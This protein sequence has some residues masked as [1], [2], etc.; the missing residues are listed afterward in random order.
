MKNLVK[1]EYRHQ[2]TKETFKKIN[3]IAGGYFNNN[4]LAL[5][6]VS[7]AYTGLPKE[8]LMQFDI[9]SSGFNARAYITNTELERFLGITIK[10]FEDDYTAYLASR[11]F[12]KMGIIYSCSNVEGF[13][14]KNRQFFECSLSVETFNLTMFIELD[15]LS[16]SHEY[17][18]FNSLNFAP[19]TRLEASF[20]LFE[21]FLSPDEISNLSTD[22]IV[23]VYPK[24]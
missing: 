16:L 14:F 22:D 11:C 9:S 20:T 17:M 19:S 5:R 24:K 12:S 7:F 2:L 21:T 13:E 15:S 1:L 3:E 23:F 10:Y 6:F 8:H 4:T 18:S